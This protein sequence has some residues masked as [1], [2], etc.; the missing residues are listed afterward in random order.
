M[1]T[2]L[3]PD[4]D[5]CKACRGLEYD[6]FLLPP[7]GK[8]GSPRRWVTTFASLRDGT[9]AGCET[10][11]VLLEGARWAWGEKPEELKPSI[12]DRP[13]A[14]EEGQDD[15]HD[16]ESGSPNEKF[17]GLGIDIR[18]GRR[19]FAWRRESREPNSFLMELP[20]LTRPN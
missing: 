1:S 12:E 19:L 9:A 14:F 20:P 6:K 17:Y 18:P 2:Q 5:G 16:A 8:P 10:C 15:D 4:F 7:T 11:G 13:K 3:Q